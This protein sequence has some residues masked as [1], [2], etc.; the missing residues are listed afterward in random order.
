MSKQKTKKRTIEFYVLTISG[1]PKETDYWNLLEQVVSITVAK[2][3]ERSAGDKADILYSARKQ[4]N[5]IE[6][7]FGTYSAGTRPDVIDTETLKIEKSPLL[8][9]QTSIQYTHLLGVKNSERYYILL[10]KVQNGVWASNFA[11]YIYWLLELSAEKFSLNTQDLDVNIEPVPSP[12]FIERLNA[13]E[14]ISEASIRIVRPNPGWEDLETALGD[15]SQKSG[16]SKTEITMRAKRNESLN[17]STGIVKTIKEGHSDYARV[18]GKKANN[19]PDKFSTEN[20]K[21][22]EKINIPP[23]VNGQIDPNIIW[24]AL[25]EVGDDLC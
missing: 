3:R 25:T 18:C 20:L 10:E 19:E 2:Q 12:A 6:M 7:R 22:T 13:L 9:T 17:K 16:S 21:R 4:K 1:L 15:Q 5:R 23:S 11:D 14:I 24:T 8:P